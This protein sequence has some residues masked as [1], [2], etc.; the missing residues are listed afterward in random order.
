[1]SSNEPSQP[2]TDASSQTP[3]EVSAAKAK[4]RDPRLLASTILGIAWVTFP[5]LAGVYIIYDL[6]AIAKFLQMD[7]EYGFWT[8]V[9]VFAVSAGLG[10][11]PTYAQAFLG[12]WVFGLK[13][14]LFGSILGFSGGAAIGYL[15][16]R[17]VTGGS[18]DHW[19]DRHPKGRIIRDALVR[20]STVR[21][22]I[23]V[24]L[25]R[26][27]P[28]SPFALTNYALG[29]TRVPFWLAMIA[30]PVGMLPRT[31]VVC[32]LAA[33][34]AASGATDIKSAYESMPR[35]VFIGGIVAGVIIFVGIG[36]FAERAL[37]KM[38]S[39]A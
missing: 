4:H 15:F 27:P 6:A 32:F 28:S 10:L 23:I 31:A 14:G 29:A 19:I 35:A 34:A 1:M 8:F 2:A 38:T 33:S 20:G 39:N 5:P 26:L 7:I 9:A 24:T 12:G 25:L 30:T 16:A 13:W 17:M 11:L 21:T 22:F 3:T 36:K 37:Q 18:V